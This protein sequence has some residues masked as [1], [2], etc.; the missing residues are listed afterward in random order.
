[1]LNAFDVAISSCPVLPY[2]WNENKSKFDTDELYTPAAAGNCKF[3]FCMD[4][5]EYTPLAFVYAALANALARILGVIGHA[6][7]GHW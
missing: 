7:D 4:T 2:A 3:R 6:V 1:M 5:R